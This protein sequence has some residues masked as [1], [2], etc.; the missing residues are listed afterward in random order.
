MGP[1]LEWLMVVTL[2]V[3]DLIGCER[4]FLHSH[5]CSSSSFTTIPSTKID[6]LGLNQH[7]A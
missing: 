3:I 5:S 6:A 4:L 7:D 2:F 1:M